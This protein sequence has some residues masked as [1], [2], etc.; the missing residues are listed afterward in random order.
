[1]ALADL[2]RGPLALSLTAVIEEEGGRQAFW[3]IRHGR[4]DRPD[5]H[6]PSCFAARLEAPDNA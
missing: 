4:D 3:A 5:F 2:P 1:M 6:D